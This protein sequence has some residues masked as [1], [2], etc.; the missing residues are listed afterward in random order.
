MATPLYSFLK[1][2]SSSS[3]PNPNSRSYNTFVFPSASEDI[4]QAYQN[5]NYRMNFS[6]FT[7][8]KLD[9]SKMDLENSDIF[10]TESSKVITDK[11]DLLVNHLRNYVANE[12][13]VIRESILNSN[14][15][16]YNPNEIRT[17]TEK[18]FWKWLRK[19]GLIEFEPAL[20]NNEYIESQDFAIDDTL[21]DDYFKE[22][23]WK[24]RSVISFTI[25]N[26]IKITSEFS[27]KDPYDNIDKNIYKVIVTT[28]SNIKPNDRI[29]LTSNGTIN[30]GF[31]GDMDFT[32][33]KV[34]TDSLGETISDKNNII[35]IY[36]KPTL[37]WNNY[38]VASLKLK[39]DKV[40]KYIGEIS[41]INNVQSADKSYTEITAYIP[42]QAGATPDVLFR[43]RTDSNYSPSMQYPIIP[44]QDQP[45]IVGGEQ[46]T[47][48]IIVKPADYPGDQYA[49]FDADQKYINSGGL[50]DRK[51]GAYFGV[52]ES[53]RK[54]TRVVSAPYVYP[55][56]DGVELDGITVDFDTSHYVKMNLPTKTS[57]DFDT[58]NSQSFNNVAPN[59]FDFNVIL[60]Y[61]D[62]EDKSF[63]NESETTNT[64]VTNSSSG[65]VSTT[66]NVVTKQ[67]ST[68]NK[69]KGIG[70]NL[71]GITI[72]GGLN[73]S[74][75]NIDTYP[76]L[77]A[78]GNQDG[79]SYIFNLNLN[80][81]ISSDNVIETYDPN[82]VYSQFSFDLINSVFR[83]VSF[84]N[85]VYMNISTDVVKMRQD[86][87]KLSTLIYT[88][89][90]INVINSKIADLN[91]LLSIY[92]R[93]QISNSESI[94]V[95][96]DESV[97][98]PTLKLNSIDARYGDVIKYPISLLYN[99]QNNTVLNTQVTVP[100]GKDFLINVINDDIADINLDNNIN[101]VLSNDLAFKQTCEFKI[102]P[103]NSKYNKKLDIS[104]LTN[105]V[106]NVDSIRGYQ[107][108]KGLNL[109][110]DNNL[111][112]NVP[113]D[114]ILKRW[115]N[116]PEISPI[117]IGMKKIGDV[118]YLVVGI[119]SLKI[120]IFR[121]GD[122]L[123]LQNFQLVK[124]D[125]IQT[126]IISDISGQYQIIGDIV[127][128]ELNF[129][130]SDTNFIDLFTE[131]RKT[132]TNPIIY[133]NS[134]NITQP[135]TIVYNIGY[136]VSI[137]CNDRV[138]TTINDKYI[139]DIRPLRKQ[140]L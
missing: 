37:I 87:D 30:I 43:V 11:G 128:N 76:K 84:T 105:T 95:S 49:Y 22:Y 48:P 86:I 138:A 6:K 17:N 4:S 125:N 44:S 135:S 24:E 85:E 16:F 32:V 98:P 93:N 73:Q 126:P 66:T 134:I 15:N 45:E 35:Y 12:D 80:F 54:A 132:D 5:D 20:P 106:S 64:V 124:V 121:T 78:N 127:N 41:S 109:P 8:L 81:N 107:I 79:L 123:L 97:S 131:M 28:D 18:I 57:N 83:R 104:I 91:N 137:T 67:T 13:V 99:N 26:I 103:K 70:T 65:S 29:T 33:F 40:L 111:N 46:F 71:Y 14:T 72:L 118:Y 114:S 108:V 38:A 68:V 53:S 9:L 77:V 1:G 51:S 136:L 139:V 56:F 90:D 19:T 130:I 50:E 59:D 116:Y 74:T 94:S 10:N 47:S 39:Y 52:Y 120:N 110:I 129:Q 117:S 102:Y 96:L 92:Q 2:S 122:V 27:D 62:V 60:W 7:L 34:E 75:Q 82:K 61:Y 115:K 89:T 133:L 21:T 3:N 31:K 58:F 63:L 69:D 23:V 42:D 55:E 25:G 113:T 36:S 100:V 112:S 140:D 88:Q 101:I 119:E